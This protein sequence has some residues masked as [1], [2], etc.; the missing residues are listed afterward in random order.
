MGILDA[1]EFDLAFV[2][3]RLGAQSGLDVLWLVRN[4]LPFSSVMIVTGSPTIETAAEAHRHGA[5]DYI[6]EPVRQACWH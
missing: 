5:L 4:R 1:G 3:I 6:G 2:D